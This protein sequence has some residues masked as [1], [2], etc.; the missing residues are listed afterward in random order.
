MNMNQTETSTPSKE[1]TMQ[2]DESPTNIYLIAWSPIEDFSD[3]DLERFD[4]T[5]I[6][7]E[8]IW[9]VPVEIVTTMERMKEKNLPILAVHDFGTKEI[10]VY[11]PYYVMEYTDGVN[12]VVQM[13]SSDATVKLDPMFG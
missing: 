5:A 3:E 12:V 9:G 1:P 2:F 13:M 7:M 8:S 4:K 6:S 10:E 11:A